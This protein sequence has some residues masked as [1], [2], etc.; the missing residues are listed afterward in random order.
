[1]A[2]RPPVNHV[3]ST[4]D[5]VTKDQNGRAG[6][7]ELGYRLADR[8]AFQGRCRFGNDHRRETLD[9]E[10]VVALRRFD[11]IGRSAAE[12]SDIATLVPML[13]EASVVAAEPLFDA[14]RRLIGAG[15][16]VWRHAFG[17][18]R[19]FGVEMDRTLGAEAEPVFGQRDV[20]RIAAVEIFTHGLRYSRI[21]AFPQSLAQVEI[22][23]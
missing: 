8:E 11:D 3:Y 10:G 4:V 21:D 17:M 2:V 20:A 1:M 15:I 23:P 22:L 13:L 18:Q 7:V 12:R 5:S 6:H 9:V 16:G 19:D 14:Q